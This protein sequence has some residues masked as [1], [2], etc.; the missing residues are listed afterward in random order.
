MK[1]L[2]F[3]VGGAE[4]PG[5]VDPDGAIR[6]LSGVV[7]DIDG[8]ALLP[9]ALARLGAL[10]LT[11][12]PVVESSPRIG[13]CVASVGKFI[14]IGLNYSDHASESGMALPAEP[15]VFMKATSSI[16]GPNDDVELPRGSQKSDWEVELGAVIG[17]KAKYVSRGNALSH[18]AGYCVVNDLSERAFQ[19]EGTGQWVKGKSADT[20]GPI[21]PWLVTADEVPDPQNL[22]LWLEVDGHRYQDGL[23]RRMVFDVAYLVSYLSQ[24]MTLY[25]GDVISTGTPPGVGLGQ[26]PPVYLRPGNVIQLGIEGLGEQ[27]QRVVAWENS[28]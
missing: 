21:G 20:F 2:R 28:V 10:D 17:S 19:L 18:V 25:P 13:P 26:K 8:S 22:R 15:V 9:D 4:K 24:F 5:I 14:C 6:D 23:T 7:R 3:G 1:L 11:A 16:C 12:L 27:R